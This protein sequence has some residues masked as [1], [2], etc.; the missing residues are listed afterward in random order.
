[1]VR[2]L[3]EHRAALLWYAVLVV[4]PAL[5]FG[6]LLWQQL[7]EQHAERREQVPRLVQDSSRRLGAALRKELDA[8]LLRED[9]REWYVYDQDFFAESTVLSEEGAGTNGDTL[10]LDLRPI[11]SPLREEDVPGIRAWF[12]WDLGALADLPSV[13]VFPPPDPGTDFVAHTRWRQEFETFV[14]DVLIHA[15]QHTNYFFD[16]RLDAVELL[17]SESAHAV[18]MSIEL[19]ALNSA[20]YRDRKCLEENSHALRESI[21]GLQDLAVRYGPFEVRTVEDQHGELH[22]MGERK[23]VIDALPQ[24]FLVPDCF[25][26]LEVQQMLLQGFDLDPAWLLEE[27]PRDLA[28]RVLG[29]DVVLHA[30]GEPA[31]EGQ[32]VEV[33]SLDLWDELGIDDVRA[34]HRPSGVLHVSSSLTE[35]ERGIRRQLAWLLGVTGAMVAS[36]VLGTRLL[37]GSVRATQAQAR[38]T[39]NF[40]AAVTHELRTPIAAVKLYGEM[41]RDGWTSDEARRRDYMERIVRE[42]DR[43]SE[44]VSKVL[45]QRML[46]GHAP[47]P[48]AG[49]LSALVSN[50]KEDLLVVGGEERDDLEFVLARGLPPVLMYPDGVREVL[51]NLVENARKYAPVL[52]NGE[53]IRVETRLDHR[54]RVLLEVADR[55]PGIPESERA[56]VFDPFY[57]LGEE[58]TR[59]TKGTGLG[60]HLVQLQ[61]RAMRARIQARAREGGGAVFRMTFRTLRSGSE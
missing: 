2:R 4:L 22:V 46:S 9:A 24:D 12:Q 20:P 25:E 33:A 13:V 28:E 36:L 14:E 31:P 61:A 17:D 18:M 59:R 60:L 38:R 45:Q 29:P 44:L 32:E 52:P 34:E 7:L 5:V 43:L 49:D 10:P 30:A 6:G 21:G 42:S 50:L 3:R 1:M 51:V 19:V 58:R 53:P 54:G 23:V 8:L 15:A 37:V 55:G 26:A 57:R 11:T 41:L 27:L 48:E 16:T 35:I 40:V 39:E 47:K 56:R